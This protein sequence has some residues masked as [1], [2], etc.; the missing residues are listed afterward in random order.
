MSLNDFIR[1]FIERSID[2]TIQLI[3]TLIKGVR[4]SKTDLQIT[5][6]SDYIFGLVTGYTMGK[7]EMFYRTAYFKSPSMDEYDEIAGIIARRSRDIK[8][9]IFASG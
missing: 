8:D 3:P 5:T 9:A 7:F 1:G 6:E 2:E 4:A